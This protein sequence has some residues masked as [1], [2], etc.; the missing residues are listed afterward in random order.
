MRKLKISIAMSL[1]ALLSILGAGSVGA[2]ERANPHSCMGQDMGGFA[3]EDGQA[4]GQTVADT[5]QEE[6]PF[7][8][9]NW[10]QAMVAHLEGGGSC[11]EE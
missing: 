9:E 11:A 2:R 3:R 10:G 6:E 8:S 1:I 4:W 5:A 7:G